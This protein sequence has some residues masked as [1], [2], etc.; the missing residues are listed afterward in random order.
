MQ[1]GLRATKITVLTDIYSEYKSS[2]YPYS[3]FVYLFT[4][5]IKG[6]SAYKSFRINYG[7]N[8]YSGKA[9]LFSC[10]VVIDA[11]NIENT[12][13]ESEI[14]YEELVENARKTAPN[15][16]MMI[17]NISE[18]NWRVILAVVQSKSKDFGG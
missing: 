12:R 8:K 11:E 9:Y 3:G 6:E 4:E 16:Y 7:I 13:S 10:K 2:I 18:S 5:Y 15:I 14:S 17:H 1:N